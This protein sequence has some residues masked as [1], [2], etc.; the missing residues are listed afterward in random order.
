MNYKFGF[1]GLEV[2]FTTSFKDTLQKK[3]STLITIAAVFIGIYFTVFT[4]LSSIKVESTFAILTK[5]N[6]EKLLRYIK[7]AF[8][9]SFLYLLFS[10]FSPIDT[11]SW[12]VSIIALL[13]LLYMLLSALRFGTI[14]YL[15]FSRDVKKYYETLESEK[16]K[17]RKRE[18]LFSRM[19]IF[20]E[21]EEK[22]R[23]HEHS[24]ELAEKLKGKK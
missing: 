24:K 14:I 21:A 20:L 23:N 16:I 10:L 5:Q 11:R 2:Y 12:I 7:N 22:K 13:L 4:L 1:Q 17:Q 9:G 6:F 18:N 19:E 8:I 3:D 15:I